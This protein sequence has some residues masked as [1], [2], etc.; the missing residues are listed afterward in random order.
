MRCS[1][2]MVNWSFHD[3]SANVLYPTTCD[4]AGSL[5][6]GFFFGSEADADSGRPLRSAFSEIKISGAFKE[7]FIWDGFP[8][9]IEAG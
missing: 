6:K 9:E 4:S 1:M 5:S 8:P 2:V 7:L 3:R